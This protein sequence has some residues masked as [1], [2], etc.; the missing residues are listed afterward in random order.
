[1]YS[2]RIYMVNYKL[3]ILLLVYWAA[4]FVFFFIYLFIFFFSFRQ[5]WPLLGL[6]VL[7]KI[8]AAKQKL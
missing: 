5:K 7:V 1:M 8:F 2:S 3:I 4:K 6:E